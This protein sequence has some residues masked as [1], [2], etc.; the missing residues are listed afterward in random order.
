MNTVYAS[1]VFEMACRQFDRAAD[2][3]ELS[4]EVRDRTKWPRR[5]VSVS[6]PLKRDDGT[7][8]VVEGYRVQH[9][10][11]MGPTKGGV[12]FHP[13]VTLGEVAALAMWMSWKCALAGLPYG[14]GKGG[15]ALNARGLSAPEKERIARR[16]MQ[17]MIPFVGPQTDVMAPDIGTDPQTMAWMM[18]TYSGHM[19][20]SVPAIVTG[21]PLEI[22][23]SQGRLEATGYG[24]AYLVKRTLES[25]ERKV[26]GATVAIQG[27]GNVGSF[28]ALG[29]LNYGAK[30]VA[31][32]DISG[33]IY[34]PAGLDVHAA[35]RHS[36]QHG[37][38]EGFQDA[39]RLTQEELLTLDCTVLIP[40]AL[41][42]V[43]TEAI[44]HK[45]RCEYIAEAANGPTT[46]EA[47]AVLDARDDTVVIPDILCNS[48]GVIVS[49]FE[50]VQDLQQLEWERDAVLSKLYSLLDRARYNVEQQ[51]ERLGISRRNAALTLGIARVAEAK[52]LRGIF[53]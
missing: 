32:S 16:Y 10:L 20:C 53:P 21:K 3:L 25:H 23:G 8:E 7:V 24:V 18:D 37:S 29:L 49:Y 14:G 44:A 26:A 46:V 42:G 28:A 15:V 45:L 38:L 52:K 47:D 50:W 31:L 51:A 36:Q 4:P 43:I 9:H 5:A 48:G 19:G 22:G 33:G 11:D 13:A 35:L 34:D 30:I 39:E 12:R 1:P 41:E 2:I 6:M 17:E 40:A 27:F